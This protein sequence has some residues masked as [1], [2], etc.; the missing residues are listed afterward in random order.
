L[1][2]IAQIK[3]NLLPP[4]IKV[5]WEQKRK[6]RQLL[7]AGLLALT[8]LSVLYGALFIATYKAETELARLTQERHAIEQE[9]PGLERF[10]RIQARASLLD[11]LV[12]RAIGVPPDWKNILAGISMH[13][14][15]NLWLTDFS[16]NYSVEKIEGLI[17]ENEPN[18]TNQI[19][20]THVQ[21]L[22]QIQKIMEDNREQGLDAGEVLLRG[23]AD[24][25][26][27]VARWL[28]NIRLVSD[29]TDTNCRFS[30]VETLDGVQVVQFE[31][32]ARLLAR[33]PQANSEQKVGEKD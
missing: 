28:E 11:Y 24:D 7:V 14:P 33:P 23:Y 10:A 8:L 1:S 19:I 5:R 32:N 16:A 26:A 15:A 6:N 30:A 20:N 22:Q 21:H 25:H 4:E 3:I 17:K 27:T 13:M 29:I 9:F 2:D 31:I 12:A 18:V